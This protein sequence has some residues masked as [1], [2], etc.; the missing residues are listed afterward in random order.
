VCSHVQ[1]FEEEEDAASASERGHQDSKQV[2]SAE[3]DE[4]EDDDFGAPSQTQ[5]GTTNTVAGPDDT[6]A[7]TNSGDEDEFEEDEDEDSSEV[8]EDEGLRFRSWS[9]SL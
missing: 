5:P 4:F 6:R 1:S 8:G 7:T 9:S 3:D 2:D